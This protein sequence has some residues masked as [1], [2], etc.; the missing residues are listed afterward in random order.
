MD[1]RHGLD[2]RE[3]LRIGGLSLFTGLLGRLGA[4]PSL[5]A[6]SSVSAAPALGSSS[7]ERPRSCIFI[8]LQGGPSHI[9]LWDPKPNASSEV[10]GP[11]RSLATGVAGMRVGELLEGSARLAKHLCLVRSVTHR[12]TNH[13]AGTYT[14]LTGSTAQP[15]QDREAHGDDFPGP[16]AVLNRVDQLDRSA[17]AD[18]SIPRSVSLPGWLSIPGPSNRMPGQ[19][20]GF[21]GSTNDPIL[22][23]G[24][25]H[26]PGFAPLSLDVA[27][28]VTV[29]RLRDR[30]QL[31][32]RLDR[33]ARLLEQE[34]DARYD[35]LR[36]SASGLIVD[37]RLRRALALEDESIATRD[38]YGWT[39]IGQSLL[40]A[41]RLVEA[42]VQFVAYN[43]F[44]QEWDTH[45]DLFNRYRQIVP[46]MDR[47]FSALIADLEQ[48]G[49]LADTLVI[50]AG[51]FGRTPVINQ[52]A[53]RDHWPNA[54]TTVLAGGGIRGGQIF[55]VTDAKGAEVRHDAV[56]PADLL[57]TM[58]TQ[59]GI[60]PETELRDRLGRPYALASGRVIDEI[61]A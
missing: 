56:S 29:P 27:G 18:R 43:A 1:P 14:T 10:R 17:R 25:P 5:S 3:L 51:E 20:G 23:E 47:A 44:N 32:A 12:F 48:R 61:V 28:G 42:G 50:N 11:F 6:S 16:G 49:L 46:P 4:A 53:G 9:D 36:E 39:R 33:A 26:R 34:T 58:W 57:A 38:R 30:M 40:L 21:L 8:L 37:G 22:V 52:G 15:D 19:F 31:L 60:S 41:R 13:I 7:S 55:G 2:R 45:G 24:E 35:Q 59:L 54:Y